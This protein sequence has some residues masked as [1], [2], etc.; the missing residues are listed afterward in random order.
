MKTCSRCQVSIPTGRNYCNAHYM[1]AMAQYEADLVNYQRNLALW[2]SMSDD[3][4]AAAHVSAEQSSVRGHAGIFGL[5]VGGV[6]WY[7]QAQQRQIDALWGVGMLITSFFFFT[8]VGPIRVLVGR[9]TRAFVHAINY[10]I[11]LW[12]LGAIISIWSP[13]INEHAAKLTIGLAVAV[14]VTSAIGETTGGHHASGV[15]SMPSK[16]SP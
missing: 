1:E 14:L 4:K 15:P 10:F 11:G 12:I 13:F 7:L 5:V 6:V 9:L 3:Q 8:G 2:D 16:P